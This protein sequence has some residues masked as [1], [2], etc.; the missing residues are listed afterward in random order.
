MTIFRKIPWTSQPPPGT[1]LDK[2]HPLYE[3]ISY[4][5]N[6]AS[7]AEPD[8]R[9]GISPTVVDFVQRGGY[10]ECT[11]ITGD[12]F[13]TN[14]APVYN[15]LGADTNKMSCIQVMRTT[16]TDGSFWAQR[17]VGSN[18][19]FQANFDV[20]GIEIRIGATAYILDAATTEAIDGLWHVVGITAGIGDTAANTA[21]F[22]DGKIGSAGFIATTD[23][24]NGTPVNIAIGHRWNTHPATSFEA[25]IDCQLFVLWVGLRLTAA[26]HKSLADNPWQ[27]FQPRFQLISIEVPAAIGNFFPASHSTMSVRR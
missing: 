6:F 16:E 24:G 11:G 1:K 5:K 9:Q 17:D 7:M 4:V 22:I 8:L 20:S 14:F 26:Q 21:C 27:I 3:H 23:N 15:D 13:D 2:A 12:L 25:D 10:I 19:I 18:A